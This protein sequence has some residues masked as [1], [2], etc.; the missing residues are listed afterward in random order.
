MVQ[1]MPKTWSIDEMTGVSGE[2]VSEFIPYKASS[3]VW[4]GIFWQRLENLRQIRTQAIRRL[5]T[6][7]RPA[8]VYVQCA[9]MLLSL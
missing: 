3:I 8:S 1:K 6:A 9:E 4:Q 2:L 7:P 5:R